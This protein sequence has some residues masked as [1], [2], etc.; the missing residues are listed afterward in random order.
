[1]IAEWI[2]LYGIVQLA[3]VFEWRCESWS[4]HI[5]VIP[6]VYERQ[7]DAFWPYVV[8]TSLLLKFAG[9][10][11][12]STIE[13]TTAYYVALH[14]RIVQSDSLLRALIADQLTGRLSST[15]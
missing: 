14:L 11:K 10:G 8:G 3:R 9:G 1:M 2:E 5:R 4:K 7:L 12:G 6:R 13:T 15:L